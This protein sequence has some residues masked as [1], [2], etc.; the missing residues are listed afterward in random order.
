M[1]SL[2]AQLALWLLGPL[3]AVWA[4]NAW[5]TYENAIESANRA[6]DRTLLGSVLAISERISVTEGT[7]AVDLPYSSLEML[8]SRLQNR[9]FYR[10][11]HGEKLLTGYPD[12]A[13]PPAR[14]EAGKPYFYDSSYLGETVRVAA[15]LKPLYEPGIR[16]PVLIQVA[17]TAELRNSMSWQIVSNSAVKELL[18]ILLAAALMWWAVNRGLRPLYELRNRVIQRKRSD[19][20]RIDV[21]LVPTELKPL[22]DAINDHT[23][24]VAR[25]TAAQKQFL[26]DAAHQLKTPLAVLRTQA[27]FASKQASLAAVNEVLD[28]MRANAER[29][30]HLVDQLLALNRAEAQAAVALDE[31][32]L[33]RFARETAFE[34]LPV[35]LAKSIDLGF[36][37]EEPV[38]IRANKVL[39]H[40]LIATLIDNAIRFTPR[41]GHVTVSVSGKNPG[42]LLAVTDTGPGIPETERERVFDRFYQIP[43]R[44]SPGCGLGLAIAREIAVLH[45][46]TISIS[47]PSNGRG[48]L[49]AV[50]FT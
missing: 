20:S 45:K 24:E 23:V 18:L 22:I 19:M 26:A 35:A 30:S 10:V 27:D 25:L 29:V 13:L 4:F 31:I 5:L 16:E 40:E 49:A 17:E 6:H 14:V 44:D 7:I 12:L 39:L 15:L 32:D 48:T 46:A 34:W 41:S 33:A 28:D 11:S 36:E 43:G 9:V 42:A 37:G 47:V 3:L 8:E 50:D 21:E 38:K 1:R 2:R